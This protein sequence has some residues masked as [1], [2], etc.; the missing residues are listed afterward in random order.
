[1]EVPYRN[2]HCK[3]DIYVMLLSNISARS[4]ASA[5]MELIFPADSRS[6]RTDEKVRWM[7]SVDAWQSRERLKTIRFIKCLSIFIEGTA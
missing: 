6:P 1:M 2:F 7:L 4:D 5:R 3:L